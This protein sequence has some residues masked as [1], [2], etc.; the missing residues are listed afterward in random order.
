[1]L[2]V[3]DRHDRRVSVDGYELEPDGDGYSLVVT[4]PWAP[5]SARQLQR[6]DVIGLTLNY[7]RGFQ[8][9]DLEFVQDW[10]IRH[11]H[12]LARTLDDLTPVYRLAGTLERLSVQT[13]P[14]ATV[15]LNALPWLTGFSGEWAQVADTVEYAVGLNDLFLLSYRAADLGPLA[16][17]QGLHRLRFKQRP[18]LRSLDGLDRFPALAELGVFGASRL[19][20]IGALTTAPVTLTRLELDSCGGIEDLDALAGLTSLRWLGLGNCG[21][22]RSVAPLGDLVSLE[23]LYAAESTRITDGDLAPLLRLRSLTDLRLAARRH[24]RPSVDE[25]RVALGMQPWS[26]SP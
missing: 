16:R 10:P 2:R 9:R 13:S 4:G 6:A 23:R 8:E 14:A 21:P 20:D 26:R 7:A 18:A 22:V 5:E 15:D 11:L 12:I 25:V 17:N 24:Y 3:H 19:I 1:M